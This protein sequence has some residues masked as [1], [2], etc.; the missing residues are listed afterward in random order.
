[1][2]TAENEPMRL[3]MMYLTTANYQHGER[4]TPLERT[5]RAKLDLMVDQVAIEVLNEAEGLK[6]KIKENARAALEKAMRDDEWL[7]KRV[8]QAVAK[9][10][11]TYALD[12][13]DD[14]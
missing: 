7:R 9:A 4:V 1:M 14:D 12:N 8:V 10:I 2:G 5:L 11:G 3:L 6:G 13:D